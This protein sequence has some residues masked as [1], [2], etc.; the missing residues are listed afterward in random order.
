MPI[1]IGTSG[2]KEIYVGGAPISAVYAGTSLVWQRRKK[3]DVLKGYFDYKGF[4]TWEGATSVTAP[5]L[6]VSWTVAAMVPAGKTVAIGGVTLSNTSGTVRAAIKSNR[7]TMTL[8]KSGVTSPTPVV[9]VCASKDW[10]GY[11]ARMWVDGVDVT[12]DTNG[13]ALKGSESAQGGSVSAAPEWAAFKVG[14]EA[15]DVHGGGD[16]EPIKQ[17]ITYGA[18]EAVFYT[19]NAKNLPAMDGFRWVTAH[20]ARGGGANTFPDRGGGAGETGL[21]DHGYNTPVTLSL[22]N[23]HVANGREFRFGT[24]GA[25]PTW[26]GE[27]SPAIRFPW[28]YVWEE[29]QSPSNPN[30]VSYPLSRPGTGGSALRDSKGDIT[31]QSVDPGYNHVSCWLSI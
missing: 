19:N 10:Y 28:G 30:E 12:T 1:N 24:H 18:L 3:T 5:E 31:Y 15:G 17:A 26:R 20:R 16:F 6:G 23:E 8:Q 7:A 4:T 22:R 2:V 21:I 13:G 27:N 11:R 29:Q 14:E 25:M 9:M